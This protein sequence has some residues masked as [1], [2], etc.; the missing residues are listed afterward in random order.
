MG[1]NRKSLVLVRKS[2][3][4]MD[5]RPIDLATKQRLFNGEIYFH[6]DQ[7]KFTG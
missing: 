4:Y 1:R 2:K 6:D 5:Q 7:E 3:K